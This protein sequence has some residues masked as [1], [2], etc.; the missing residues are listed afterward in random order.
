MASLIGRL[1]GLA[2]SPQG[3]KL[4]D[5]A[6]R[7]AKDPRTRARINQ[8]RS[9]ISPQR[10]PERPTGPSNEPKATPPGL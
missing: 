7:L 6:Q 5:R 8:V 3:R 9:R 4:I 1:Q 10:A 2:K